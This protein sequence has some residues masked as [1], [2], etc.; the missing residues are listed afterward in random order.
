LSG[1]WQWVCGG[2]W[3]MGREKGDGKTLSPSVTVRDLSCH[4]AGRCPD[5]NVF[6]ESSGPDMPKRSFNRRPYAT[7]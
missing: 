1:L 5:L 3:G 7:P 2:E 4:P 6:R